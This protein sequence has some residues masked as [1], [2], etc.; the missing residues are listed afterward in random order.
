MI[1]FYTQKIK[2]IY[3]KASKF[4]QEF[5]KQTRIAIAAAIGFIIAFTWRDY[6][7]FL[8]KDIIDKFVNSFTP[9]T[10][11]LINALFITLVGVLIIII[12][13][14]ILK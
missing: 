7:I 11:G 1:V 2:Y 6:I 12:S 3:M 9:A 5:R 14:R 13:S 10:S 8:A 4:K